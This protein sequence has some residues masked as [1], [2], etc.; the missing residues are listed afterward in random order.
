MTRTIIASGQCV[1]VN[2]QRKYKSVWVVAGD[3]MGR[4]I[5]VRKRSEGEALAAWLGATTGP[6]LHREPPRH[7][8]GA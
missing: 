8:R 5:E 2:V 4:R 1:T 7:R 3:H 6:V